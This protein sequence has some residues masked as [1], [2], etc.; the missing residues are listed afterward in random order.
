M[1]SKTENVPDKDRGN[2]S[3]ATGDLFQINPDLPLQDWKF[4]CG[5][6]YDPV[7]AGVVILIRSGSLL[8]SDPTS[9][10]DIISTEERRRTALGC[11]F[12]RAIDS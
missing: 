5:V 3:E 11:M 4:V 6:D 1:V 10:E 2:L 7:K 12:N 9:Y 8:R